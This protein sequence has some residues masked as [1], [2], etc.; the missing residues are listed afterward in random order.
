MSDRAEVSAD[1]GGSRVDLS[2]LSRV[3]DGQGG[4]VQA[5]RDVDLS[6]DAGEFVSLIGPSGCGK[7]TLLRIVAGLD[8]DYTGSVHVAGAPVHGPGIDRGVIFQ[9]SR[10]F[11]WL[12]VEANIAAN[13]KLRDSAVRDRVHD[14]VRLVHLEGFEKS[15]P[16]ELSGGMAQRVAIARALLREPTVLHPWCSS[17]RRRYGSAFLRH[18]RRITLPAWPT[19]ITRS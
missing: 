1:T 6:I 14:L 15:Y 19:S 5:L 10:L 12:T 3:F 13:L 16:K 8:R 4:T 17:S 18:P 9:E 2:G 7:S 11:P